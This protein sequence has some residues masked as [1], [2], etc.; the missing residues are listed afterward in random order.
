MVRELAKPTIDDYNHYHDVGNLGLTVTNYGLLGQ[1][2]EPAL[3]D[4]PSCQY[5]YRSQLEKEQIEH[6]SYAG[7]W[8]G[9]V[10]GLSGQE[11]ILVSTV[12]I[13]AVL[14]MNKSVW[15][16]LPCCANI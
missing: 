11:E 9:G 7:L 4:Q 14:I 1:G 12:I 15:L 16:K 5:K 3:Q 8:F 2:Y 10:G 6:F 13:D